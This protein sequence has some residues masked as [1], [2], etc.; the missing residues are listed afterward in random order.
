MIRQTGGTADGEISTR[1]N[2][3]CFAI[4]RACGGGMMPSCFPSS[5]ITRISRT[6]IRSFT[7]TRSSRRGPDLS[8]AILP[9]MSLELSALGFELGALGFQLNFFQRRRYKRVERA[10]SEITTSTAAHGHGSIGRFLVANDKHVGHLVKLCLPDLIS[11]LLLALIDLH[12]EPGR[13]KALTH[14]VAVSYMPVCD[15][16]HNRLHGRQ[17]QRKCAGVVLDQNRNE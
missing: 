1:S 13:H 8:K 4:T 15:R 12:S 2:P 3:F 5:S 14:L 16:Q 6:R 17:P 9:P 11:N 10:G 7:R